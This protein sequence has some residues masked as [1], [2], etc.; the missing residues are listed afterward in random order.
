MVEFINYLLS[1]KLFGKAFD[2]RFWKNLIN[3]CE[4]ASE[5]LNF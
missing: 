5:K 2:S 1:D 4:L 3:L